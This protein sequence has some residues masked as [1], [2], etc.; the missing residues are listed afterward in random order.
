M[1]GKLE[2]S[3]RTFLAAG[4]VG[5]LSGATGSSIVKASGI[6]GE[7]AESVQSSGSRFEQPGNPTRGAERAWAVAEYDHL[8]Q[9]REGAAQQGNSSGGNQSGSGLGSPTSPNFSNVV[10]AVDDLGADPTGGRAISQDLGSAIK[11][12]TLILFPPGE[13]LLDQEWGVSVDGT[14]GMAGEGYKQASSPLESGKNAATFV[15]AD[16]TRAAINFEA[17]T[18]LL[19]NFVLDQTGN[20]NSISILLRSSGF[21][22][23]RDIR[24]VGTQ[25]N[26]G[27]QAD[28]DQSNPMCRF[29]ADEGATA[30]A[31]RLIGKHIGLPGDKNSGGAP[32][33]WV[34]ESNKGTAQ[35]GNCVSVGAADNG[36]YGGRTPGHAQVKGGKYVNN[37]VSQL[38]Y[39]GAESWADGVS[40]VVD[41]DNYSGP[42]NGTPY[43]EKFGVQGLK[44]ERRKYQEKKP[45]GAVLRNAD[46]RVRSINSNMGAP[47]YIRGW[48]GSLK[49]ENSRIVNQLD[50]T[51]IRAEAP[52]DGNP[53]TQPPHNITITDSEIVSS[54]ADPVIDIRER[55]NSS[56]RNTC[57]KVPGAGPSSING[58]DIGENVG[59]GKQCNKGGLSAPDKVGASGNLSAVNF[60]AMDSGNG[61]SG[62]DAQQRQQQRKQKFFQRVISVIFSM[63]LLIALV[64]VGAVATL[65]YLIFGD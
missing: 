15:A 50:Q 37:A 21:V 62:E 53:A 64:V 65:F 49:I 47:I 30:R 27:S 40:M 57:I 31:E 8:K 28:E 7:Q 48:A 12:D 29:A 11:P 54:Y 14:F 36:L 24:Y 38:R 60:S 22:Q 4:A 61:S 3:R 34:G 1:T 55:E 16:N 35:M 10:N 45:S 23:A 58:M 56:I 44:T 39:D 17:E 59:F 6:T 52:G 32:F 26:T 2:C 18:G 63:F 25:D 41:A 13:Y 33:F 19:A 9:M 46:V 20:R 43:N 42:T 51:T 5:A